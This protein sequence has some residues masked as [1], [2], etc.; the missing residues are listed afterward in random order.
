M[1]FLLAL[2]IISVRSF[3]RRPKPLSKACC[4]NTPLLN[5]LILLH[6]VRHIAKQNPQV[7]APMEALTAR[8]KQIENTVELL[9]EVLVLF[10]GPDHYVILKFY[11]E[12]NL[13]TWKVVP[14]WNYSAVQVYG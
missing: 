5:S 10:I 4:Q 14:T 9:D 6:G 3:Y 11:T 7:K 13:N 1:A 2:A 8:N 12:T